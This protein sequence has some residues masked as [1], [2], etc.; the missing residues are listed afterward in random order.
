MNEFKANLGYNRR[1][2]LKKQNENTPRPQ[3]QVVK[4]THSSARQTALNF[5]PLWPWTKSYPLQDF[6]SPSVNRPETLH[7]GTLL[8]NQALMGG[9]S[10]PSAWWWWNLTPPRTTCV[11]LWCPHSLGMPGF[12]WPAAVALDYKV[13]SSCPTVQLAPSFLSRLPGEKKKKPVWRGSG[14]N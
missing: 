10:H 7:F 11:Q 8:S 3:S 9:L 1:P 6:L 12:F 5:L 2:H 14:N 4:F 13:L